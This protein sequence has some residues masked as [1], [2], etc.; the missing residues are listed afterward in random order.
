MRNVADAH[1]ERVAELQ[2]LAQ[3]IESDL[4]L[5]KIGP[6]CRPLGRVASPLPVLGHDGTVR[7]DA[8]GTTARFP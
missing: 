2:A 6:G 1:P 7:A 4:G 3:S 5:T 8:V